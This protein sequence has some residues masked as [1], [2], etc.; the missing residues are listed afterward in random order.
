LGRVFNIDVEQCSLRKILL[1]ADFAPKKVFGHRVLN[2]LYKVKLVML[3]PKNSYIKQD[4]PTTFIKEVFELNTMY[5]YIFIGN[6]IN[7]RY[8]KH[9]EKEL[10]EDFKF[11]NE[12]KGKNLSISNKMREENSVSIHVRRGDYVNTPLDI[13]NID[14]YKK[15][16]RLIKEKVENP[17]FY[18]FSNDE[19][20]VKEKFD[21]LDNK[22]IINWNRGRNSYIDMQLMSLCKHNIIANS[23][24]SFWGAYLN[25]NANKIVICPN[26]LYKDKNNIQSISCEDWIKIEV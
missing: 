13:L 16:I 15:A 7:E 23:T 4:T 11:T 6:W 24:F 10:K 1:L 20:Y 18:I 14:Y 3:G 21:F 8:F 2:F 22:Y 19:N 25:N 17:V 12:L 26:I 9:I 5:S